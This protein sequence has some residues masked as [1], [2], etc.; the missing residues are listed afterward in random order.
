MRAS[1]SALDCVMSELTKSR[2]FVYHVLGNHDLYNFSHGELL[3]CDHMRPSFVNKGGINT[4]SPGTTGYY[5]FSPAEGYRIIV[6][7]NYEISMLGQ[8][9]TSDS[10]RS[11]HLLLVSVNF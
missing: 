8:D 7:D 1:S 2:H 10:Y 5:H 6:L 11:A 4:P 3:T 9:E